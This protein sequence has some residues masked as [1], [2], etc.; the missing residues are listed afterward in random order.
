MSHQL[1]VHAIMATEILFYSLRSTAGEDNKYTL[2][3][4]FPVASP[5]VVHFRH[6]FCKKN[7][8]TPGLFV[9]SIEGSGSFLVASTSEL[10]WTLSTGKPLPWIPLYHL[11]STPHLCVCV[12]CLVSRY[13]TNQLCQVQ[14][15]VIQANA[16]V[17]LARKLCTH[18]HLTTQEETLMRM[19][20]AQL[21]AITQLICGPMRELEH[22][23]LCVQA[24]TYMAVITLLLPCF[25]SFW[26]QIYSAHSLWAHNEN[27]FR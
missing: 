5:T 25:C 6:V 17:R 14:Q 7:C 8:T 19:N 16:V 15:V 12:T 11:C 1:C 27:T 26:Q 13:E 2:S 24:S 20:Q 18:G 21:E 3:V 4:F 10:G 9:Y 22:T 23:A